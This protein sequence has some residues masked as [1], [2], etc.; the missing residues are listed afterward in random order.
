MCR[1]PLPLF[2]LTALLLFPLPGCQQGTAPLAPVQ[3]H[4]SY[5]GMWLQNGTIVF[6][7]DATRGTSGP[8]SQA[9]IQADGSYNLRTDQGFGAVPGWHRVTVAAV[10]ASSAPV[11][12]EQF[13]IPL[14][15]VPDRYRD[16]DLSRLVCEVKADQAN[17]FDFNLA[18]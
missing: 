1:T 16:P 9:V 13:A 14:S 11:G 7:P 18:D 10:Y 15:L 8:L 17:V 5:R 3:G 2:C 6:I 12:R 4:I